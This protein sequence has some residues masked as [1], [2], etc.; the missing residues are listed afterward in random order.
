MEQA[1]LSQLSNTIRSAMGESAGQFRDAADRGNANLVKIL[2]TVAAAI[3]AQRQDLAE[4][5]NVLSE[6]ESVSERNSSTLQAIQT[7]LQ[8]INSGIHDMATGIKNMARG[9]ANVDN[10]IFRL[11]QDLQSSIGQSLL[12]GLLTGLSGTA[13]SIV[14]G[15]AAL[16]VGGLAI[17]GAKTA[18]DYMTSGGAGGEGGGLGGAGGVK[19]VSNPVMAKDI[20]NYLTKEKGVDHAHAV[21][22]LANIQNESRFNSGAFNKNDVNGPSGGLFQHHDN[23]RTGEHR[24][25]D[26]TRAAGPNWQK[27]WKGQIDFA[28][29]E[30]EM[31]K[32][33]ATPV[34]SGQD[35]AAQFVYKF[36][37]PADKAGEASKRAG[38][39]AAVEK[40]IGSQSGTPTSGGSTSPQSSPM[41]SKY[42]Q[43]P[44][45][46]EGVSRV[47]RVG[48]EHG[49]GP[50]SGT[51]EHGGH[52]PTEKSAVTGKS[53]EGVNPALE[54][55]FLAAA[56]EY[57]QK[58]GETVNVN[59]AKRSTEEQQRLW[60]RKQ[61]G[62]ISYP[63]A[64]PGTSLHEKGLAI[65]VP[66]ATA[67]KM[68][69]MGIL[70][71]NGLNRPVANDPVHIQLAGT[72]FNEQ[73]GP[74][75][76]EGGVRPE[77]PTPMS[78]VTP[79]VTAGITPEQMAMMTS[80][81]N[82]AAI[83]A[84]TAMMSQ[85]QSAQDEAAS[86]APQQQPEQP[87]VSQLSSAEIL[88]QLSKSS[89]NTQIV[90]QAAVAKQAQQEMAQEEPL[91]EMLG[92]LFGQQGGG[93]T[94]VNNSSNISAG[95]Y[96]N[97]Y[98]VGWPDWAE[99]IGGNH[100]KEMKNYKKNM[101]G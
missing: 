73:T 42:E 65:D 10:S 77:S 27:N 98:D 43:P 39:V 101:W 8:D 95:G 38:N 53:L 11:N 45:S 100:W 89:E 90:Q 58:T 2:G 19:Q 34:S 7:E 72:R 66:P 25:S 48:G 23:L 31:R 37:K 20:Y 75:M 9:I 56:A 83:A 21:G 26:M 88:S 52:T 14:K 70:R 29:T 87:A 35:A 82:P 54:R 16:A 67:E 51:S 85:I 69:R 84:T 80:G 63:V 4:L 46:S 5:Q 6:N 30:G 44:V 40:A 74:T 76:Q 86:I 92:S 28:L 93:S 62:E 17:G 55:A 96:N 79:G 13:S 33:L 41:Q 60:D 18:M 3:K 15:I 78:A 91:S 64:K 47:E 36:E 24:F 57:K 1:E 97:Q 71:N 59:S 49:H 81:M 22:M 50:I 99:M 61:R 68:D 94:V 12:P 32:Y